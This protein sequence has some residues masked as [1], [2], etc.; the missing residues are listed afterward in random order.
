MNW[1]ELTIY[2]SKEGIEPVTGVL[3]DLGITGFIIDD[4]EEMKQFIEENSDMWDLVDE[5]LSA[6][7]DTPPNIKIYVSDTPQGKDLIHSIY[8]QIRELSARDEQKQFGT[9]QIEVENV[10]DEDWENNW[11]QY[12]KPFEVG[13]N[14]VI[15]PTWE[16]YNNTLG[17]TII[18]IDPGNSFGSGLHETTQMCL[19]ALERFIL[20]GETVI[21]VGC[22]SGILSVAAALLGSRSVI[23]IDI[24]ETAVITARNSVITNETQDRVTIIHGDLTDKINDRSD[25]VIANL[26]ANVI[27]RLLPD[28]KRVLKPNGLFISSGIITDTVEEVQEAYRENHIHVLETLQMGDWYLII[29]KNED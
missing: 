3:L 13:R 4:P 14:L 28:I 1:N 23:G 7:A 6:S 5:D 24:D 22:G 8:A 18:Q 20:N 12:F 25:I 17:K 11:K 21:D 9:L 16:K 10:H 15:K 2:T 26:F 27:K 19:V 29:G